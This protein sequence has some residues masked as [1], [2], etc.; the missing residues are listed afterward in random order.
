MYIIWLFM[1]YHSQVVIVSLYIHKRQVCIEDCAFWK[2]SLDVILRL[3][4]N[5]GNKKNEDTKEI[6]PTCV[7]THF[8]TNV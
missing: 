7:W 6:I 5:G 2:R 1:L 4:E 3:P 8:S